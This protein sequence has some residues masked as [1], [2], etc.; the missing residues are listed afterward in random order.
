MWII[1][2]GMVKLGNHVKLHCQWN[3]RSEMLYINTVNSV[4]SYSQSLPSRSYHRKL[5]GTTETHLLKPSLMAGHCDGVGGPSSTL[6]WP[7][8]VCTCGCAA[9]D[10]AAYGGLQIKYEYDDIRATAIHIQSLP[11][12][13]EVVFDT[14]L[15]PQDAILCAILSW[16]ARRVCPLTI[17]VFC[18]CAATCRIL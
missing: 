13:P 10:R 17:S 6:A 18:A 12:V 3:T 8:N 11:R 9:L 15:V 4:L 5:Q 1:N 14:S 7:Q 2:W 16:G